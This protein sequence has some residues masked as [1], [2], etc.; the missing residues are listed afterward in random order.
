MVKHFSIK[1]GVA[2]SKNEIA[3]LGLLAEKPMYGYEIHQEI[4]R[5]EMDYWAKIKLPSIYSTLTRLEEQALIQSGK[6]K[7]GKMPE[8][9]VYSITSSGR[10][11]LKELVVS[12]LRDEDHPEWNFGVGVAFIFGAPREIV[13]EALQQRRQSVTK[14]LADL[15]QEKEEHREK[16]PF[17]WYM[18]IEHGQKHME[19]EMEWLNSLIEKVKSTEK[20]SCEFSQE[21][22]LKGAS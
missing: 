15:A 10:E 7:V 8:R 14:C 17:N 3:V 19:L 9:N 20:W 5:R 6:E 4:K 12:F 13:L 1:S 18:L 22:F 11:K 16:I 21:E 2:M